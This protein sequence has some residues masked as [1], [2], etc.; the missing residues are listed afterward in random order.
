LLIKSEARI[1]INCNHPKS[2]LKQPPVILPPDDE[3]YLVG[4][5]LWSIED[6][7]INHPGGDD[8]VA[9]CGA[10]NNTSG[11]MTSLDGII[12]AALAPI[13][14][15]LA[16]E[17]RDL[18]AG[19]TTF[20]EA[21]AEERRD[22]IAGAATFQEALAEER[23]DR[24]AGAATVQEAIATE[25]RDRIEA[26][27]EERRDRIAGDAAVAIRIQTLEDRIFGQ[28]FPLNQAQDVLDERQG[29]VDANP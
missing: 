19:A 8:V 21:L 17:R 16:A 9:C 4:S 18:I 2:P 27:A 5:E 28:D 7:K 14:K 15:A 29:A 20:Q 23:R 12:E 6:M 24:I 11:Y 3:G 10:G 25:R 22:R 13:Q 26:L 1:K